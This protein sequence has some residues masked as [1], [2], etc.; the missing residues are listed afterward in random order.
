MKQLID[1]F[2]RVD[3]PVLAVE[4]VPRDEVSSYGVIAIAPG[5]HLGDGDLPGARSRG[6]A[7][8]RRGAVRP[9]DHRPLRADAGHLPGAG[10]DQERSDRRDPADQRPARAAEDA[11]DL[12]LRSQRRAPRHRQQARLSEGGGLLRAAPAGSRRQVLGLS[13]CRSTCRRRPANAR[14]SASGQPDA[15]SRFEESLRCRRALASWSDDDVSRSFRGGLSSAL[16]RLVGPCLSFSD[17][18]LSTSPLVSLCPS[19]ADPSCPWR[20]FASVVVLVLLRVVGDVP[21]GALE[22]KRGRRHAACGPAR[23]ISGTSR[24]ADRTTSE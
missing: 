17:F 2:E 24:A 9:R 13:R 16:R 5:A 10:R 4:R 11:A 8:A 19:F 6:E 22:L 20:R 1:V 12:R 7:A 18:S 14:S 23:R 3:G 15:T 21:A